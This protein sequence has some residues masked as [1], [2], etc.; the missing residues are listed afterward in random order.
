MFARIMK[1]NP[2]RDA[3]GKFSSKDKASDPYD[4]IT[5]D[6]EVTSP[7]VVD[8]V[9]DYMAAIPADLRKMSSARKVE[10]YDN[11]E[12]AEARIGELFDQYGISEESYGARGVYMRDQGHLV[13]SLWIQ[14]DRDESGRNFYHE[15]AHTLEP[16]ITSA[17]WEEAFPEWSEHGQDEGFAEA[18]SEYMVQH[19]SGDTESYKEAYPQSHAMFSKLIDGK[20]AKWESAKDLPRVVVFRAKTVE[21]SLAEVLKANPYHDERGRFAQRDKAKFVSV[22]GVFDKQRANALARNSR[23]G[24]ASGGEYTMSETLASHVDLSAPLRRIDKVNEAID[25]RNKEVSSW[26]FGDKTERL[27]KPDNT[28]IEGVTDSDVREAF[29]ADKVSVYMAMSPATLNKVLAGDEVKNSLQTGKGTF[30][31]IGEE[32]AVKEKE[33]LGVTADPKDNPGGFPKY[34]YVA[35]KGV[36]DYDNIVAFGYGEVYVEFDDSIRERTTVTVGDSFNNN[37]NAVGLKIPAPLDNMGVAQLKYSNEHRDKLVAKSMQDYKKSGDFYDMI[38]VAE[39]AEA[40]VYGKLEASHIKAVHVEDSGV[41]KK[42]ESAIK[43][44]GLPIKVL[45]T[46]THTRL[47]R[48]AEGDL[49]AWGKIG[50]DDLPALGDKYIDR[51]FLAAGSNMWAPGWKKDLPKFNL[52]VTKQAL[53]DYPDQKTVPTDVKRKVMEEYIAE[54]SKGATGTLPKVLQRKPTG[55][56]FTKTVFNQDLLKEYPR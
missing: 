10:V 49:D 23:A 40:Q 8:K 17:K 16:L 24:G 41:A 28:P 11:P 2:Y 12:D 55:T 3:E 15:F 31:T 36:M 51:G 56:G 1:A 53:V 22:G 39:Y 29:G 18:F 33:F 37:S 13:S 52:P 14:E 27:V 25:A 38:K 26:G 44:S 9:K 46:N 35:K 45:P 5:W 30:K 20:A 6:P 4:A 54:S 42:L 19:R 7:D 32:R 34:G 50:A 47:K 43:K 48:L 21:K